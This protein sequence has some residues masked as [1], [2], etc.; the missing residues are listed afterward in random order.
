MQSEHAIQYLDRRLPHRFHRQR[1]NR[2][3]CKIR[4]IILQVR[5]KRMDQYPNLH[6]LSHNSP[7]VS[8]PSNSTDAYQQFPSSGQNNKK[9]INYQ[10][11][12]DEHR[13]PKSY[14]HAFK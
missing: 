13:S 8:H 14:F 6:P 10:K 1:S 12:A 5:G 2:H 11:V 7:V 9:E 3:Q 4:I